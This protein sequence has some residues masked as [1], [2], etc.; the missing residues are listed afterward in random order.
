MTSDLVAAN[1][2][3]IRQ[4]PEQYLWIYQRWRYLPNN[5]TDEQK[6]R[7]P[8]YASHDKYACQDEMLE[9]MNQ[10]SEKN[11]NF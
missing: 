4:Y 11:T 9:A 7:F 3:L 5:L 10:D 2:K 8:F 1:E 6:S